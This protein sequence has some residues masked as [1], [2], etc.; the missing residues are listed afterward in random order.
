VKYKKSKLTIDGTPMTGSLQIEV[1]GVVVAPP[2]TIKSSKGGHRLV[3]K[4]DPATLGL[5]AGQNSIRVL[6]NG[7]RSNILKLTVSP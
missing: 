7:L 5:V 3:I 6:A 2:A 4:G 1:N